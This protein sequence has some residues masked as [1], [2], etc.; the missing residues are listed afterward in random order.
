MWV[1][2]HWIVVALACASTSILHK[3]MQL[4]PH[5]HTIFT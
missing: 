3:A 4:A 2:L 5:T 1:S